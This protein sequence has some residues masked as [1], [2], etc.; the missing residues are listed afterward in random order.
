MISPETFAMILACRTDF[1][2][3]LQFIWHTGCRPQEVVRIEIRH[4]EL[5]LRRIVFPPSEAKGKRHPRVIYLDDR[6]VQIVRDAMKSRTSR[7]LFRN[8]HGKPWHRGMIA[9]DSAGCGRRWAATSACT[10]CGIRMPRMHS[11]RLIRSPSR[12]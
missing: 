2:R 6:A 8:T 4:V 11:S 9:V 5:A 3:L 7:F 10:T 1:R 12:R